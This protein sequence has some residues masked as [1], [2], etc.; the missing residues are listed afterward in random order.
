MADQGSEG[1]LSPW[2]RKQRINAVKPYLSGR[3]LDVGCGTGK[4]AQWVSPDN[5]WGVDIDASSLKAAQK[6]VPFHKFSIG[7]PPFG[8]KF[9]TIAALA[10]IEHVKSP[11]DFLAT[12]AAYLDQSLESKII[13][14]TPHMLLGWAHTAGAQVGLFSKHANEEHEILFDRKKLDTVATDAGLKLVLYGRFLLGANQLA[15]FKRS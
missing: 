1:F 7:M 11:V 9:N 2:L 4:L 5:Y 3:V 13:C 6:E 10:V 8:E 15:M 14:T 12:L